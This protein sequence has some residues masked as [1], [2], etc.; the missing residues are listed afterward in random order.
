MVA[1]FLAAE[2]GTL[3]PEDSRDLPADWRE[4]YWRSFPDEVRQGIEELRRG[5]IDEARFWAQLLG[6]QP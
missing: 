3:S 5:S 1:T 6:L 4:R 2:R